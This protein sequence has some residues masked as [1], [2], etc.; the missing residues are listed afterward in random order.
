MGKQLRVLIVEDS[1]DDAVLLTREL[2]KGGY[3]P[4]VERVDTPEAMQNS[5]SDKTWDVVVSDYIMP[6]FSGLDALKVLQ[7]SELDLPFIIVSGK[8][9][10]DTAVEVMRA[11][12]HDY[13]MK[14]NL[15]RLIPAIKRELAEVEVRQERKQVKEDLKQSYAELEEMK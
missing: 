15:K 1:E 4:I 8:I 6:K 10:E 14:S 11:G 12:A 7:K 13:I 5:L 9:G 2:Q 3:T